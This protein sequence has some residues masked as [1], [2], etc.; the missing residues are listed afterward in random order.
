MSE[1]LQL[2]IAVVV[3]V[4]LSVFAIIKTVYWFIPFPWACKS[5]W[6][7]HKAPTETGFDGCSAT[8]KCSRCGTG[9]LQD[10]QG[11]WF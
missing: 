4:V 6:G 1:K 10:S 2:L 7:E 9:V 8:G 5:F 3:L 11:G